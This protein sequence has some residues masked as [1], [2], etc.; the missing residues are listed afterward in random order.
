MGSSLLRALA[1]AACTGALGCGEKNPSFKTT[2]TLLRVH[3]FGRDPKEPVM[4]DVELWYSE[5]P[6]KAR[7]LIRGDKTFAKCSLALKAG[8]KVSAQVQQTYDAERN[9][10]RSQITR[11]GSCDIQTDAKDEANYE[12][13]EDCKEIKATGSVVGVQCSRRRSPELIARCPWL[14]RE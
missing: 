11:L 6:G 2:V 7:K 14:R 5:C 13:I 3:A 4:M 10:Y 1:F 8:D 12:A 9:V